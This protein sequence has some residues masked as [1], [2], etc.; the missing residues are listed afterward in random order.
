MLS[1]ASQRIEE[2][3]RLLREGKATSAEITE[4]CLRR[5]EADEG[6]LNA[7]TLVTADEARREAA[8]ADRALR[9]GQDCGPLHGVP[10]AV[11]DLI[12]VRGLPTT[13]ASRVREGHVAASDAPVIANLRRA[14]AVIVGKTNLDEFAYGTTSENSAFGPVRNPHDLSRSPGGSSGGSGAAIAAGMALAAVG[15]DTGGSVRIPAAACGVV[16]LKPTYA[17]LP[18][19]GVVPLAK[20]FDHVG[21]FAG[22]VAGAWALHRAMLGA[23]DPSSAIPQPRSVGAIR[24]ALPRRY[25]YEVVDGDVRQRLEAVLDALRQRGARIEE[26]DIPRAETAPAVYIHIHAA[27][28]S[29]YHARS[30]EAVPERYTKTVRL[31]LEMGRYILAI[32]HIRARNAIPALRRAVDAALH[33]CD[34]LVL[35]TMPM[36]APPIGADTAVVDGVSH[37]VRALMLRQTQLFNMTGHPAISLPCGTAQGMPCGLQLV[38]R[39]GQTEALLQLALDVEA[40]I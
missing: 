19:D 26:R 23:L 36:P 7:F 1:E 20:T 13:A 18:V 37:Q 3:A 11:K 4:E 17:E 16:G 33:G 28:G 8:E 25:F 39:R 21:S 12:D 14:G 38:G 9:A 22:S 2:F 31:R 24:L 15:T 30:L 29:E 40:M 34:A 27:E 5:I 35:P 32:D 6:R 10:V